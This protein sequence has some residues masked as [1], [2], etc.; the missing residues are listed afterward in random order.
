MQTWTY[1]HPGPADLIAPI[2]RDT[3]AG[4]YDAPQLLNIEVEQLARE[5]ALVAHDR[6]SG[7]EIPPP[8]E[9]VTAQE[10]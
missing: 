3:V 9:T 7:F 2:V 1:S 10:P 8:R 6:R 5:L 4:P